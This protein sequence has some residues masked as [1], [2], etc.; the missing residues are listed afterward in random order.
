MFTTMTSPSLRALCAGLVA[1]LF[2]A[3]AAGTTPFPVSLS[4]SGPGDI[5]SLSP[6][7]AWRATRTSHAMVFDVRDAATF[8]QEHIAG[9]ICI[10]LTT[11]LCGSCLDNDLREYASA[12]VIVY[13]ADEIQAMFAARRLSSYGLA[14]RV[15]E[16]GIAGWKEHSLPVESTPAPAGLQGTGCISLAAA[17]IEPTDIS[18]LVSSSETPTRWDWRSATYQGV[19]GDWTTPVKNQGPCG[20]CWGFAAMGALEA[21]I[22]IRS[23]HPDIDLDLSEQHLLSCPAGSGGCSGW[24]AFW[25]YSYIQR[26]GGAI[27]ES[28]FP[29]Q[30]NDNVPC[31]DKCGD[32]RRQLIP[33][34]RYG[35]LRSPEREELKAALI[36]HGPLVAE[37][38]VMSGFGSYTGGVYEHPGEETT[39]DINHQVVIVGYDDQ[40]GCWIVKNSWGPEWGEDGY[41]RIAYGDCMIEHYLLYV[42]FSPAIARM[43]GPYYGKAGDSI[44]FDA[45]AS[46]GFM[47][48]L[49]SYH[50]EF[51]DGGTA[52]GAS[53]THIY[54][55]EGI[56]RVK[57]TVTDA[58]G[59]Q[60]TSTS[61]VYI[62]GTPPSVSIT[63][64]ERHRLYFF[65]QE[66]RMLPWG[67]IVIGDITVTATASDDIAGV[68]HIEYYVDG[69][70][71]T[72]TSS[73]SFE[74]HWTNASFGPHRLEVRAV[75]RAGNTGS[76]RLR[77]WT[78][79]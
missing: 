31:D 35:S 72:T 44:A 49:T 10:P 22:N 14:T 51:G 28:C 48:P 36:D 55:E 27:T 47:A 77:I 7:D 56:Y 32:W 42:D 59:N 21:V 63:R 67:I 69:R 3:T 20:S 65:D 9:A 13:G 79:M 24:N 11:L 23:H 46:T 29:Y 18:V 57:L 1:L 40:Q 73:T 8:Q 74:W 30:A 68:E 50:W 71:V 16:G 17:E 33:I 19:T 78:W 39:S 75:D 61:Q 70:Y 62:D 38:A 60:G 15:L 26:S 54:A 45:T 37:M 4:P 34:T 53:P 6:L 76:A 66:Q 58:E 2:L 12:T 52:T 25:A 64:P 5:H 43:G 41:F